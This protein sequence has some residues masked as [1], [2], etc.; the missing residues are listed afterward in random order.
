VKLVS[1]ALAALPF[2]TGGGAPTEF[3]ILRAG[4]NK[5]ERGDFLFDE[6]A[7][8]SVMEAFRAKG[9]DKV[10]I[11]Y[12]HQ[13]MQQPPGGG[14]AAKPAAG[15]FKPEV[16]NGELWAVEVAWTSTAS[17]M[18]APA[19]GAPEYRYF[20][21]IL[22]FDEQTMRIRSIKNLALTNDPAMDEIG[23]L[24]AATAVP[25]PK[26]TEMT[27]DACTALT[28]EL[29]SMKQKCSDL[30]AKL[31]AYEVGDK[32]KTGAMTTLTAVKDR[33]VA[34][35]G[36]TTEAAALG[37]LESWKAKASQTDQLM[38]ERATEQQAALTTQME[39]VLDGAEKAG[40]L[41]PAMRPHEEK[42]ALAFGAGKISKEGV[43]YL[44]AKW[45]AAPQIVKPNGAGGPT[46]KEVGTATL[47]AAD[48]AAAKLFGHDP[49][50][51]LA[52]KTEQL[53]SK[54]EAALR[55]NT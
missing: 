53:K 39:D 23:P 40:K 11:D 28:A 36:Q 50:D 47:T 52:Y 45:G 7:A 2:P 12:E 35:T 49:K 38:A 13:S 8:L 3:R 27:C 15:W 4:V 33:V 10:Q 48:I 44:T 20:S 34:L 41:A 51:V 42:G 1:L 19:A 17:N 30:T 21:P 9:L 54:A 31:S 37:V 5:T 18:I 16:R 22:R 43:E 26:E 6:Q 55:A 14:P 29:T 24:A 32:E 25:Q 46:E